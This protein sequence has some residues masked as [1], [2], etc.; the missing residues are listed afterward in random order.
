MDEWNTRHHGQSGLTQRVRDS[1]YT[2]RQAEQ[3]TIQFLQQW[4]VG[5]Q[6]AHC[7]VTA[8]VRIVALWRD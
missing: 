8:S 1:A 4:V 6:V 3:E 5:G 2:M 7:A